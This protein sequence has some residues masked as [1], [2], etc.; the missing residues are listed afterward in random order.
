VDPL[1]EKMRRWSPYNYG[2]NNPM[3]FIDPDGMGPT[4]LIFKDL[5][6]NNTGVTKAIA[7]INEGLGGNYATTDKNGKVSLNVTADQVKG[8]TAEQKGFYDTVNGAVTAKGDV[9]IAVAENS[10]R[11]IVGSY[12][13][14]TVDIGDINAFG[15]GAGADKF[16]TFGHE[17]KEQQSKQLEGKN[18]N[19]AHADGKQA[20]ANI[21]GSTRV[22]D[23][24]SGATQNANGTLSGTVK[25]D[26]KDNKTGVTTTVSVTLDNNN[27]KTV[28]RQ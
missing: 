26:Y 10:S 3:R 21:K 15:T 2:F 7:N 24:T 23:N 6:I 11:V 17:I 27:V 28:T 13:A 18:F 9:T 20:E 25:N 22:S 8:F 12:D 19:D 4:D 14:S 1:A 16:S 5:T